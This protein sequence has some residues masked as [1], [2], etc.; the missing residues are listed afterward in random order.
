VPQPDVQDVPAAQARPSGPALTLYSA[1]L[2]PGLGLSTFDHLAPSQCKISV[3]STPES[4]PQA[5][6]QEVPTAHALFPGPALTPYRNELSPGL[7][8]GSWDQ[9]RPFQ[10]NI[11]VWRAAADVPQPVV[12]YVPAAQAVPPGPTVTLCRTA[13]GIGLLAVID[14]RVPVQC[15][16]RVRLTPDAE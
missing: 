2:R 13:L 5:D 7:G 3:L 10:C 12:Q 15:K 8:L 16:M 9:T 14:Q 4:V 11:S 1:E 6:A